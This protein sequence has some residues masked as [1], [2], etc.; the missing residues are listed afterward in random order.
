MKL[1]CSLVSVFLL[2]SGQV[3]SQQFQESSSCIKTCPGLS[4]ESPAVCCYQIFRCNSLSPSGYYWI[5]TNG[6]VQ[7]THCEMDLVKITSTTPGSSADYP[8]DSCFDV[9][10]CDPYTKNGNYWIKSSSRPSQVHCNIDK[11]AKLGSSYGKSI[12]TSADSCRAIYSHNPSSPSG[13]Y[14]IKTS[15]SPQQ[16]YCDMDTTACGVRGVMRIAYLDTSVSDTC[17][18]NLTK[19][20]VNGTT[21]C[22]RQNR[23]VP[24]DSVYYPSR[25]VEYSNICG[26]A[27]GYAHSGRATFGFWYSTNTHYWDDNSINGFYVSGVTITRGPSNDRTH[28]WTYAAGYNEVTSAVGNCPCAQSGAQPPSF[29]GNNYFCESATKYSP[30]SYGEW[31]TNYTMW[32]GNCY[33]GSNCCPDDGR[34]WFNVD[35]DSPTTQDIEVRW[36]GIKGGLSWIDIIGLRYLEIL[37]Y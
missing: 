16:V 19:Y 35:L 33:E 13:Y 28:V 30:S 20:E 31:Y 23:T 5:R 4:D 1:L 2:L 17:P 22:G 11:I 26:R 9:Y 27:V 21:M 12:A 32:Q 3:T 37:I 36:C 14:W 29:V 24:C 34:P 7:A 18:S 25:G 8:A 6:T 15:S 10:D